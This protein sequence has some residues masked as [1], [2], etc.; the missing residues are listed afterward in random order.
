MTNDNRI[1][2]SVL[3]GFLGAGKTTIFNRILTALASNDIVVTINEFGEIGIDHELIETSTEDTIRC[4]QGVC[5]AY[6]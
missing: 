5:V 4:N 3:S 2:V 1:P 6:C